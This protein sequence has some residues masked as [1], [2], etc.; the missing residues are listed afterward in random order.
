MCPW[1][2][3]RRIVEFEQGGKKRAAYAEAL[4]KGLSSDLSARFGRGFSS[5]SLQQMR[6]FYITYPP[7]K[8]RQTA[9]GK[10]SKEEIGNIVAP[11]RVSRLK[12]FTSIFRISWTHDVALLSVKN[13]YAREFY[14]T[15]ALRGGWSVRQ[16]NHQINTMIYERTALSR[17]KAV[18]LTKGAKS[19]P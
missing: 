12:E 8:I 11:T 13:P 2:A 16:L 18:M 10:L 5:Q 14:E 6:Q 15:E 7:E 1:E 17:N 4:L 9:S 19:K 3:G